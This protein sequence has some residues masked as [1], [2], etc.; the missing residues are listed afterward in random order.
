MNERCRG[1]IEDRKGSLFSLVFQIEGVRVSWIVMR[2]L[3]LIKDG[4]AVAATYLL[5]VNV[6]PKKKKKLMLI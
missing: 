3:N 2:R 1:G 6:N 5:K 4:I